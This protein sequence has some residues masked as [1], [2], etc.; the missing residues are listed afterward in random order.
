MVE[1]RRLEEEVWKGSERRKDNQLSKKR[2]FILNI[3]DAFLGTVALAKYFIRIFRFVSDL[4][5]SQ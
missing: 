1:K 3:L 2:M 4:I 5:P